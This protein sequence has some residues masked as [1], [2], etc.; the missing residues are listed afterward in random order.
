MIGNCRK[1]SIVGFSLLA[2]ALLWGQ[3]NPPAQQDGF[4]IGVEVNMITVP[5]TVRQQEG[6]FVKG[7][8]ESAFHVYENGELQQ[9]DLFAQEGV[10]VR[11]AV[12]LDSS[13]SVRTEWG[14]IKYATKK[15]LERLAP[16][17]KFSL[18]S[19]SSDIRLKMN[20][21]RKIDRIDDVLTSIYCKGNTKLWDAIYLVC[22]DVFKGIREKRVMI[23][24]SDGLDNESDKSY[25]EAVQA[26]VRS[27]AAIYVVSKTDSIRQLLESDRELLA[28][29]GSIP[30]A[31]FVQA[32]AGLRKLAQDTGGRVLYPKNF[33][34]L[35]AVYAQVD[36]ELRSQY[37]L[38]YISTNPLKDGSYRRIDV[39]VDA[40]GAQVSFRPGYYA[41]D[42]LS[43]IRNRKK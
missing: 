18:V 40:P 11:I 31:M 34:Q 5:V 37:T 8:K 30:H 10:P 15:F 38:G 27:E 7:L 25:E 12:V 42:E 4:K 14:A 24:M 2:G 35:D 20:W 1:A 43:L 22:T 19:F 28:Y 16:D 41:P 6:G 29:Y 21:G 17:D 33:G 26:A 39:K 13:G 36:E 3:E 9:I 23:I 32:D